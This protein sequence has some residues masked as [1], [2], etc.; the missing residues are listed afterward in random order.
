MGGRP[1]RRRCRI[2]LERPG[3][4]RPST[5]AAFGRAAIEEGWAWSDRSGMWRLEPT[6][7]RQ[8]V[9]PA[10][11]KQPQGGGRR[12]RRATVRTR[13]DGCGSTPTS[14]SL[15]PQV[16]R[17]SAFKPSDSK[18]RATAATTTISSRKCAQFTSEPRGGCRCGWPTP[19]G[20][21][22][23]PRAHRRYRAS[24]QAAAARNAA[25]PGRA[26]RSS[27]IPGW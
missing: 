22:P 27:R 23:D 19:H 6:I 24:W 12:G 20:W 11:M 3:C 8:L 16:A 1:A 26:A 13:R 7:Q 17:S 2:G 21:A 4:P 14:R 9:R 5:L 15:C 25:S 10:P 18:M